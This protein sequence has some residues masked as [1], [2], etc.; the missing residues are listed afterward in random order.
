MGTSVQNACC[1][2]SPDVD[3]PALNPGL[4]REAIAAAVAGRADRRA[5]RAQQQ[6]L[7]VPSRRGGRGYR[8][9]SRWRAAARL[10]RGG[11]ARDALVL[12]G[13]CERAPDGR[14]DNSSALVDGEGVAVYRKIHLWGEEAPWFSP[15]EEPAPV[16]D[17]RFGRIG[18]RCGYDI[19]FP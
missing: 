18:W 3:H 8:R 6:W 10:D 11:R 2:L 4:A 5:A 14:L 9:S 13:F 15:G 17:R 1:Q 16:V 19:E 7:R 12:G